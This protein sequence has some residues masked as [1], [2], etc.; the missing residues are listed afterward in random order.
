MSLGVLQGIKS[1]MVLVRVLLRLLLLV[2]GMILGDLV[3]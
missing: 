1:E 2:A 3:E